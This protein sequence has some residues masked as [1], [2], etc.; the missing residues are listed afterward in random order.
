MDAEWHHEHRPGKH[1][2]G[3][4]KCK[5]QGTWGEDGERQLWLCCPQDTAQR[6]L[7]QVEMTLRL[8]IPPLVTKEV[9]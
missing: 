4:G 2:L 7:S 9:G 6:H 3:T 8:E 1:G 5:C